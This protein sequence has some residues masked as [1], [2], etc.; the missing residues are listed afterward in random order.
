MG[1]VWLSPAWLTMRPKLGGLEGWTSMLSNCFLTF[2]GAGGASGASIV[3]TVT[4]LR[5]LVAMAV[6]ASRMWKSSEAAFRGF[7]EA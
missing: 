5:F 2:S 3:V 7:R 4:I 6:Y 1:P